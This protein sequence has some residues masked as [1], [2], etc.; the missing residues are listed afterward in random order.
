MRA[1]DFD[2]ERFFLEDWPKALK[3]GKYEQGKGGLYDRY[4]TG[5]RDVYCCLGVACQLLADMNLLPKKNWRDDGLLPDRA[6]ELLGIRDDGEYTDEDGEVCGRL[7]DDNDS[8]DTFKTI[9]KRIRGLY[10]K[11]QFVPAR[12]TK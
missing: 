10:K 9:A 1:K 11:G 5:G 6:V 12:S 3:S 8:G 4:E 7:S 2:R